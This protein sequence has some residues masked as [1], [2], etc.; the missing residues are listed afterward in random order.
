MLQ[1][2]EGRTKQFP[3]CVPKPLMDEVR[4]IAKNKEI[5][6]SEVIRRMIEHEIERMKKEKTIC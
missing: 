3:M 6:I 1:K 2:G 5:S 4:K